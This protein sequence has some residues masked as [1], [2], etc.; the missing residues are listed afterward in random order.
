[1]NKNIK[2]EELNTVHDLVIEGQMVM[3]NS[4]IKNLES[5]MNETYERLKDKNKDEA[6]IRKWCYEAMIKSYKEDFKHYMDIHQKV[7][8][9]KKNLSIKDLESIM[10][11]DN[12]WFRYLKEK[13][14]GAKAE[15]EA[16]SRLASENFHKALESRLKGKY[17]S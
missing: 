10:P 4:L 7:F 13:F 17:F 5:E 1:M 11:A 12:V 2:E 16:E 8:S 3:F 15:T 14:S 6:N 9:Y